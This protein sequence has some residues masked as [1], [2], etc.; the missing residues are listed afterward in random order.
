MKDET[1]YQMRTIPTPSL[2]EWTPAKVLERIFHSELHA[3]MARLDQSPVTL[4]L[5]F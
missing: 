5:P 2:A 3:F 4:E 1:E